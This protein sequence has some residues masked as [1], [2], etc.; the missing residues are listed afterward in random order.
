[1]NAPCDLPPLAPE[2]PY[3]VTARKFLA[4]FKPIESIIDG[5][6]LGR[7][8]GI[9]TTSG[10]AGVWMADACELAGLEVPLL[11]EAT[12][13]VLANYVP[14]YGAIHN[15]VDLT[16]QVT[17]NPVG[18]QS[19]ASPLVGALEALHDSPVVDA[20]VLV[21]NMSDGDVLAREQ[22][23]LKALV[24]RLEKPVF[25]YSHAP[26]ARASRALA[27]EMGLVCF[28]STRRVA[29]TIA[30]MADYAAALL[31]E[32]EP[33]AALP[34]V[35]EEDRGRLAGGLCEYEAKALFGRYGIAV[36]PEQL[37][38]SAEE[39][40]ALAA[41]YGA[42]VALKIQSR[43]IQ[44][45]TE[46]GGV[47]LGVEG[48]EETRRD[49]DILLS[50]AAEHAPD[51]V[52]DGILVQ[53]MMAPGRELALGI[54]RD[55]DFGPMMMV[56]L[57]GIYIEILKDVVVEPLPVTRRTARAML[58]RLRAWPLLEGARGQPPAD[59]EAVALLMENLSLLVEGSGDACREIDLNPVFVYDEGEGAVVIDAMVVGRD[60]PAAAGSH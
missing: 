18:G 43:Q 14:S 36:G 52:V 16:A 1:M 46:I 49:Y 42:P 3:L 2:R 41:G 12:Q 35:P 34:A 37:A 10:G 59:I 45:K 19:G 4:D 55:P 58:R 23:G 47:I 21:A 48:A 39:A 29:R 50:R 31:I 26:A 51:A 24:E 25:L 5:L 20:V 6:P 33:Q 13:A 57:G 40:A 28:A 60:E 32:D 9:L 44:H 38:T 30:G 17:V 22:E 11:D 53:K 7:R 56:G 8:V 27:E 15:P 54:V